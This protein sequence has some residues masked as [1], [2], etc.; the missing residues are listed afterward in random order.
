MVTGA[1]LFSKGLRTPESRTWALASDIYN[2]ILNDSTTSFACS[3]P[4]VGLSSARSFKCIECVV[5][6]AALLRRL[7]Q[8]NR[9][10]NVAVTSFLN[11]A[12]AGQA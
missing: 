8:K 12:G 6:T 11:P 4:M 10:S 2:P 3:S 9:G 1:V 7:C 5:A